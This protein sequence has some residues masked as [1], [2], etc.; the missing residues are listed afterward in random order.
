MG[1][2]SGDI[3][4]G[5]RTTVIGQERREAMEL[6]LVQAQH[7]KTDFTYSVHVRPSRFTNMGPQTPHLLAAL[8]FL[9]SPCK[10]VPGGGWCRAVNEGLD[11][12]AFADGLEKAHALLQQAGGHLEACGYIVTDN[13][14]M[15][16]FVLARPVQPLGG[17]GHTGAQDKPLKQSE[18]DAFRYVLTF[19]DAP[20]GRG[21]VTHYA[22]K[23]TP[24]SAD[25][26]RVFGALGLHHMAECPEF[27]F[28]PCYWSWQR[29]SEGSRFG[30]PDE[31]MRTDLA[32]HHF[33]AHAN[34]FSVAVLK[35]VEA[36]AVLRPFDMALLPASSGDDQP[37]ARPAPARASRHPSIRRSAPATP[38]YHVAVS[39]AGAQRVIARQ[40][41]T[42]VRAA[43]YEVFFDEFVTAKLWGTDLAASLDDVYRKQADF[44]LVIVSQDYLEREWTRHELR[45]A[46]ARAVKEK[47]GDYIL[48]VQVDA[49]ELPGLVPTIHYVNFPQHNVEQIVGLLIEKFGARGLTP[50]PPAGGMGADD[51]IEGN[52]RFTEYEMGTVRYVL[53]EI[54]QYLLSGSSVTQQQQTHVV[55]KLDALE[56]AAQQVGRTEWKATLLA[57]LV[58]FH[59]L[60]ALSER[61][62][63][64]FVEIVGRALRDVLPVPE[65]ANLL[66]S[67]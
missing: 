18:D 3:H 1:W 39:F 40:I 46:I 44:C 25:V 48:P 51:L 65:L 57:A 58:D 22:P 10:F 53:D 66:M 16:R 38:H 59:T 47:G 29:K 19:I 67:A 32:H 4:T 33:D 60:L 26:E 36:D 7:G 45:S 24:L 41:A 20:T 2:G 13:L 61:D 64:R 52:R 5:L 55:K 21:W 11:L 43:G 50:H 31:W 14:D 37:P 8:E 6:A 28:E 9:Q 54:K 42:R 56:A 27:G 62:T 12:R 34:R 23:Q 15:A 30:T 17:D 49:V 35:L 63:T